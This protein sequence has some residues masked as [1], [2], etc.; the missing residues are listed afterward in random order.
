MAKAGDHRAAVLAAWKTSVSGTDWLGKFARE[1]R[2]T[3]LTFGGYP[4]RYTAAASDV[5]S[6]IAD[7]IRSALST[8]FVN[9]K[10][11]Q[12]MLASPSTVCRDVPGRDQRG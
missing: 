6:L 1:G 2:A 5:L 3:Q 7:A 11:V 12:Q 8:P 9:P 4:N 10:R